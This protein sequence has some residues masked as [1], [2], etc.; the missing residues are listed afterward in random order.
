MATLLRG[1]PTVSVVIPVY[2]ASDCIASAVASVFA[3]TRSDLEVLLVDDG[4]HDADR[5]ETAIA[6]WRSEIRVERQANAGAGAAR[7]RGV[8]FSRGQYVAF[9]DADDEWAPDFLER[10][11]D[12]LQRAAADPAVAPHH[13]D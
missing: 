7:N 13:Q 4:S 12:R 9:L 8:A 2:D 11:L 10:Q 5:L 1:S 3:Q 6:R